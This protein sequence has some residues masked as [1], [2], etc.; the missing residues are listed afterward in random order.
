MFLERFEVSFFVRS[1]L[2]LFPH[3]SNG[4][5]HVLTVYLCVFIQ[6]VVI[7]NPFTFNFDTTR[8]W[9]VD[10]KFYDHYGSCLFFHLF[11]RESI[12]RTYYTYVLPLPVRPFVKPWRYILIC[13]CIA[14]W[15]IRWGSIN[16]FSSL[17]NISVFGDVLTKT[18]E[19]SI[20]GFDL[21][22][23]YTRVPSLLFFDTT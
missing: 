21:C 6:I 19:R 3:L 9:C 15:V 17:L 16:V 1:V 8:W 11:D 23:V 22:W 2:Y 20:S 14:Y 12:H 10:L 7:D 4:C 5:S 13:M 18:D